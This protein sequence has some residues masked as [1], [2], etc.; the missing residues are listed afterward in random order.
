M[1][2]GLFEGYKNGKEHTPQEVEHIILDWLKSQHSSGGVYLPGRFDYNT[3]LYAHHGKAID[4]PLAVYEGEVSP[5]YNSKL[6]EAKITAALIELATLL[7]EKL[8]QTR[9][10]LTYRDKILI[11]EDTTKKSDYH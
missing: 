3:M 9:I 10:Y 6:S 11:L 4:E 8:K 2:I 5:L 7:S 1:S